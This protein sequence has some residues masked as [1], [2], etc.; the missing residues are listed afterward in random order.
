[1]YNFFYF[2]AKNVGLTAFDMSGHERYRNLWTAYYQDCQGIIFVVDSSER[3][4][5]VVAKDELDIMLDHPLVSSNKLFTPQI[6]MSLQLLCWV[7]E[8]E[9]KFIY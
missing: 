4:R 1:M 5:L 8:L 2:T 3:M 9:K 6:L 7:H